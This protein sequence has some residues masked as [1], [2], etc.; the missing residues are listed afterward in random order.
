MLAGQSVSNLRFDLAHNTEKNVYRFGLV[1]S[2][3]N[4]ATSSGSSAAPSVAFEM[5]IDHAF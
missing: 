1:L 5:G 3:S 4:A 2:A